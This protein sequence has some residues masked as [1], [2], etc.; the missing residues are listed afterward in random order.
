M[1]NSIQFYLHNAFNSGNCN[2]AASQKYIISRKKILIY[3]IYPQQVRGNG[4][5]KKNMKMM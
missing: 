5:K 1:T 3:R 2:K 4:V